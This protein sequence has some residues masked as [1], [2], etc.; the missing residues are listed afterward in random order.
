M[1]KFLA[2]VALIGIGASAA[3]AVQARYF[4]STVGLSDPNN[5]DS[6]AVAPP[7][8]TDPSIDVGADPGAT[9]RFYI[10]AQLLTPATDLKG[11]NFQ[12]RSTGN[13]QI[14]G[15]NVWQNNFTVPGFARWNAAGVP[16]TANSGTPSQLVDISPTVA[17][18][19]PGVTNG[20][21]AGFDD[22]WIGAIGAAVVGYVTVQGN[23][24]EVHIINE[25]T[26]FL[27]VDPNNRVFLGFDDAVGNPAEILGQPYDN[28]SP[29]ALITPE[30]VSMAL[31]ALG[32]LALRRR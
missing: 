23:N 17:V 24:G 9:T 18:L 22:Q 19:E 10:W 15:T 28:A 2:T 30:P 20:A 3:Q 31:M 13:V 14:T 5:P 4:L 6:A 12:F 11:F 1:K 7:V 29:E 8:G 21:F 32:A 16:G 25:G 26:G 27:Q